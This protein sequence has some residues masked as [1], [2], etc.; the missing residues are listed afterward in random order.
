MM[1][2][3]CQ[4]KPSRMEEKVKNQGPSKVLLFGE[5]PGFS[6]PP[7]GAPT[8]FPLLRQSD[9]VMGPGDFRF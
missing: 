4:G 3:T 1:D 6:L 5:R 8:V 9:E 7:E 2:I